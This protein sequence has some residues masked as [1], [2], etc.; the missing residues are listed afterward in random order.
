MKLEQKFKSAVTEK[1]IDWYHKNKR[2]LPWR[3]TSD[4][5]KIWI[6]E[7]MIQQTQVDQVLPYYKKF[8]ETFPDVKSVFEA[9]LSDILKV[10]E[11][12]GYYARARNLQSAAT[13]LVQDYD[14]K[15][16]DNHDE[17]IKI[18][19]IGP[20]TAAAIAS[21]AFNENFPVVDGNVLRVLARVLKIEE[22]PSKKGIKSKFVQA[23]KELLPEGHAGEFNQAVMELGALIC[24][25]HKP[26]CKRCPINFFCQA[27]QT[28]KDP[29]ILPLKSPPKHGQHFNVVV[30]IIWHKGKIFIDQ[31]P[32]IGQLGGL[33]E[34][35]GGKQEQGETL[36]KCLEREI[37]D[38][39]DIDIRVQGP[40]LTVPH[41]YS[42]FSITLHSFQ[43]QF[44]KGDPKP[45]KAIA[46][47]WVSPTEISKYAFPKA[48]KIILDALLENL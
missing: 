46:W 45:K 12:M 6:S 32:K 1:L 23:A 22:S 29:S 7:V 38:E 19:G 24:T 36:E 47:K 13:V 16:P 8:I 33:W 20:Y 4:P 18:P 9:S 15:M 35:P 21:I 25:P 31:R 26:K 27:F 40:F 14:G 3:E 42:H 10:W 17:L 37:L 44:I 11:G 28:L 41:S 30:G 5:Y 48:N 43:C 39:M 34:F 2:D